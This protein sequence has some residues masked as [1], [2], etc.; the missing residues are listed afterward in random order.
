MF[1]GSALPGA[2]DGTPASDIPAIVGPKSSKIAVIFH[3]PVLGGATSSVLRIVPLLE[4]RGWEFCFW[5]DR[6]SELFDELA[7]RGYDVEGDRRLVAWSLPVLRLPPGPARRLASTPAYMRRMLAFLRDRRPA[8]VHANSLIALPEALVA[9]RADAPVLLHVHEMSRR[10]VRGR[11]AR[12][13]AWRADELVAVSRASAAALARGGPL[14]RVVYEA[15]PIPERPVSIR[16]SPQPFVVGSLGVISTRKGS[17]VFV[18]AAERVLSRTDRI[19]FRLVGGLTDLLEAEWGRALV[20][21]ARRAG[22]VYA[23]RVD[24]LAELHSWDGF[25]LPSRTDPFP[26]AMLEAQASG[27]PVIGAAADGI[28]EQ[29]SPECGRLV[30]PGDADAL[31]DAIVWLSERSAEERAQMGAAGRRRVIERFTLE[32]QAEAMDRAYRETIA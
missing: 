17:D 15:S 29:V 3:E 9:K 10:S 11:I 4:Q 19:E 30:E 18:E 23:E 8:L 5:V 31:A 25:V 14:P 1:S 12:R 27:L 7:G 22:I 21:R 32:R 16:R 28:V 20:A 13:L 24:T 6:P 26:I 2:A